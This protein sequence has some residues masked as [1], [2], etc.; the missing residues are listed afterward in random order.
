MK[1]AKIIFASLLL[2]ML[3]LSVFGNNNMNFTF[4]IFGF[5]DDDNTLTEKEI[6]EYVGKELVEPTK[7][8]YMEANPHA[9]MTKCTSEFRFN[10]DRPHWAGAEFK[11]VYYKNVPVQGELVYI[12][13]ETE[14]H[15]CKAKVNVTKNELLVQES[16]FSEWVSGEEFC[17]SFC[18]RVSKNS[19][20]K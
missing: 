14:R 19:D 6:L 8:C 16:F 1:K 18:K 15:I 3:T 12:D 11:P 5:G 2:C 13:C 9:F 4:D 10:I 17:K 7:A 20:S